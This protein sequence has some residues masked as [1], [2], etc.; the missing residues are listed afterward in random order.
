MYSVNA[1]ISLCKLIRPSLYK[2]LFISNESPLVELVSSSKK[3]VV[4]IL[5]ND[6]LS[7]IEGEE[8]MDDVL[9]DDEDDEDDE[10]EEENVEFELNSS[11]L[12]MTDLDFFN[13]ILFVLV[14]L[15]DELLAG[16]AVSFFINCIH[17]VLIGSSS[18]C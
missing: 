16:L 17:G 1:K 13:V 4:L 11:L 15:V 7:L 10:V 18:M 8:G 5:F 14:A 6:S 3:V 12:L 9:L 2:F